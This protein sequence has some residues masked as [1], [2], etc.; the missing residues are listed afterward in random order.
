VG[1]LMG[2]YAVADIVFVGGSLVKTGGHNILEPA[3][4]GKPVVCG[5]WMF[6][7]RDTIELFLRRQA[8]LQVNRP[9]E[10]SQALLSLLDAPQRRRELGE[11]GR[12]LVTCNQGATERTAEF[13]KEI[14]LTSKK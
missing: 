3:A 9:Q 4:L 1:R 2:F 5:P 8:V 11:Q 13:L 12:A 7:F 6:N 14:L 10:L